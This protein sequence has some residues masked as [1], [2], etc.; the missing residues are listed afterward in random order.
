MTGYYS[1]KM[2]ASR[3]LIQ[4]NPGTDPVHEHI[5]GAERIILNDEIDT[6][7]S[8]LIHRAQNHGN[9][10]PDFINLKIQIIKPETIEYISSMPVFLVQVSDHKSAQQVCRTLLEKLGI[11]NISINKTSEFLENGNKQGRNLSGALVMNLSSGLTKNPDEKGI[12]ATT[13][14]YT[15]SAHQIIDKLLQQHNLSNTRL[16]EAL[17]LATKVA[18]A[19][20]ARAELCYSDNPDYHIGYVSITGIGYFRIPYLK[21]PSA[22]G[23]RVFFVDND[24][25]SWESY[26]QYMRT[27]PILINRISSFNVSFSLDQ[28]VR[29]IVSGSYHE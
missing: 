14:D 18:H 20:N 5:S 29:K 7:S 23:G 3:I 11:S 27:I 25:F 4:D 17:V 28:I 9:G 12:R 2:R 6:I 1:I 13:M 10:A 15:P 8:E 22:K 24:N 26:S 16:K 19:P 21:S